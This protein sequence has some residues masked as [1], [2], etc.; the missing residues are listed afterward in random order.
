[1][2]AEKLSCFGRATRHRQAVVP[3]QQVRAIPQPARL[4]AVDDEAVVAEAVAEGG[5]VDGGRRRDEGAAGGEEAAD[6][7][8]RVV[9]SLGG[10][11]EDLGGG[12][13]REVG[14]EAE[15]V[16]DRPLRH[17]LADLRLEHLR[18]VERELGAGELRHVGVA[19]AELCQPRHSA[20]A[21]R[22]ADAGGARADVEAVHDAELALALL[23][24][25]GLDALDA[26]G[27]ERV[28][29]LHAG[30]E[31]G[32]VGVAKEGERPGLLGS[33]RGQGVPA[34]DGGV[35]LVEPEVVGGAADVAPVPILAARADRDGGDHLVQPVR[36]VHGA[37]GHELAR[38][39]LDDGAR[40]EVEALDA[41]QDRHLVGVRDGV[42]EGEL[43]N[44]LW[45]D[46]RRRQH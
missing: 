32:E 38:G 33:E 2:Q 20:R 12:V 4:V 35:D 14:R 28:Q 29:V 42:T 37:E 6:E 45:R 18:V 31:V 22:Q 3:R 43:E 16:D 44:H 7:L 9:G 11:P 41:R 19:L 1:M 39:G 24:V 26:R 5:G 46:E 21:V 40:G 13:R 17:R 30:H 10:A 34:G 27:D 8:P 15:G 36:H 23:V 25:V